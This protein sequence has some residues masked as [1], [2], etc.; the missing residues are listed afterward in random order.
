MA[1]S[2]ALSEKQNQASDEEQSWFVVG[3][4]HFVVRVAIHFS[5]GFFLGGEGGICFF[6]LSLLDPGPAKK[7]KWKSRSFGAHYP[8]KVLKFLIYP[9][10]SFKF[11]PI[12]VLKTL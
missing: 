7:A 4:G 3:D 8:E 11:Q 1:K 5:G 10:T 9:K 6:S 2:E 12:F